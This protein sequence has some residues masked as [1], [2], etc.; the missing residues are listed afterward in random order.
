M[1]KSKLALFTA[2]SV[3]LFF[4]GLEI[5]SHFVLKKYY[6]QW[7][8]I[9]LNINPILEYEN[10]LTRIRRNPFNTPTLNFGIS[11]VVFKNMKRSTEF[12]SKVSFDLG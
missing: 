9:R 11:D 4:I 6:S 2:I 1:K 12:P 10:N 8:S 3:F 7:D 5:T